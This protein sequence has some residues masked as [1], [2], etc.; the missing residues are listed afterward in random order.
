MTN[1]DAARLKRH[2]EEFAEAMR[3]NCTIPQLRAEKR[4]ERHR[5]LIARIDA[6]M[7]GA[8]EFMGSFTADMWGAPWMMRD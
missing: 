4:E 1:A 8:R 6:E 7:P 3:R 2:R 5:E